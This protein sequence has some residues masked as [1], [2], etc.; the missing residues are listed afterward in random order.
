MRWPTSS[1]GSVL[2]LLEPSFGSCAAGHRRT[3][4]LQQLHGC[5]TLSGGVDL[6]IFGVV[7]WRYCDQ[8][9]AGRSVWQS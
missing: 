7:P 4:L 9:S 2:A 3:E 5:G 8:A 1:T 6:V